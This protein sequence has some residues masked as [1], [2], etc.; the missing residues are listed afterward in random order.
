MQIMGNDFKFLLI[1]YM[2]NYIQKVAN[3]G[4]CIRRDVKMLHL[5]LKAYRSTGVVDLSLYIFLKSYLHVFILLYREPRFLL[6]Y[7]EWT[8]SL[9]GLFHLA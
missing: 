9:T 4:N 3:L 8:H 5:F 1:G 2:I 6:H 7:Q